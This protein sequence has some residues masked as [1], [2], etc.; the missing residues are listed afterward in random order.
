[1]TNVWKRFQSLLPDDPLLVGEVAAHNADGTSTVTLPDGTTLRVRGQQ[2][3][4]ALNA[5]VR[6]GD[7]LGEAPA[8]PIVMIEI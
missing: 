5:F 1:M 8:L 7:V 6:S 3:A 4:V 2:V